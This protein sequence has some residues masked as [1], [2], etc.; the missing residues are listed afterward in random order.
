MICL[1]VNLW[2]L[3]ILFVWNYIK[4][5]GKYD[6]KFTVIYLLILISN[7]IVFTVY[8]CMALDR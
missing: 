5:S 3:D 4:M 7:R 2:I 6:F 8:Y 1:E